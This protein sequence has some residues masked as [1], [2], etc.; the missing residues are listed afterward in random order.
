MGWGHLFLQPALLGAVPILRLL[1]QTGV[2]GGETTRRRCPCQ[3]SCPLHKISPTR[4]TGRQCPAGP[5]EDAFDLG[6][7]FRLSG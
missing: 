1:M 5:M 4:G 6:T 7:F 2:S 3:L